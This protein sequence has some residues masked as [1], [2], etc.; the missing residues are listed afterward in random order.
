MPRGGNSAGDSVTLNVHKY[1]YPLRKLRL[2]G[3]NMVEQS[4]SVNYT[5]RWICANCGF[6]IGV[7]GGHWEYDEVDY[8]LICQECV[9]KNIIK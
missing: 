6:E 7:R 1:N 3:H 5:E 9:I 8:E 4:S 2:N